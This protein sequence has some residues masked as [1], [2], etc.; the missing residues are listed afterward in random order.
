MSDFE[1]ILIDS[2][3]FNID[4]IV[5]TKK[6]NFEKDEKNVFNLKRNY[7]DI[8]QTEDLLKS[9]CKTIKVNNTNFMEEVVKYIGL[10]DTHYGDVKDCYECKDFTLQIMYIMPHNEDDLDRLK[11]NMLGSTL[12]FDKELV[13]GNVVLFKTY[14][15]VD[16]PLEDRMIDTKFTD[17]ISL[18]MNNK[19][20]TGVYI[21]SQNKFEQIFFNNN[22][23]VVDQ[24]NNWKK[25]SDIPSLMKDEKYGVKYHEYLKFYLQF[26][27]NS[28]SDDELNEP[29]CRLLHGIIKGD[30]IIYS[31]FSE[32][33]F[34]ELLVE[35]VFDLL[36]VWNQLSPQIDDT[37][38]IE[39]KEKT[40]YQILN[41]RIKNI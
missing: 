21:N 39:N 19:Y 37:A 32:N 24:F 30:G 13:Y 6:S 10:D 16:K 23:E 38:K 34:Y 8:N 36:K 28:E 3:Q 31:P 17:L 25:S 11:Y 35:D 15:S 14:I 33:S 1:I 27:Y 5:E 12:T 7:V 41:N 29:F 9:F 40:K 2:N 18:I 26:V 22:Y 20:H 4:T